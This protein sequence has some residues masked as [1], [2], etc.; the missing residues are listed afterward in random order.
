MLIPYLTQPSVSVRFVTLLYLHR[1][2]YSIY[3]QIVMIHFL[4]FVPFEAGWVLVDFKRRGMATLPSLLLFSNPPRPPSS[5]WGNYYYSTQ[6]PFDW[7]A[8]ISIW[9]SSP[10]QRFVPSRY[11]T[12]SVTTTLAPLPLNGKVSRRRSIVFF[13]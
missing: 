8:P 5:K 2:R 9:P 4:Q 3:R 7:I 11:S 10:T 6:Y 1:L 12:F 13:F